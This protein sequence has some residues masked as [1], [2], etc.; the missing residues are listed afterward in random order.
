M[1]RVTHPKSV[2]ATAVWDY[3]DGMEMLRVFWD[4]AVMLD[5]K[6]KERDER[7]MPLSGAGTLRELWRA[8]GLHDV[9]EVPLTIELAFA[10]FDDFWQPFLSGQGPAGAYAVSLRD[11]ARTALRERLRQ[12]FSNGGLTLEA[13]A[14]AVRGIVT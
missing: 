6:T 9:D 5:P 13:R 7:H 4:E 12:R 2:V 14:W 3:G 1:I 10:S 8:H 11:S